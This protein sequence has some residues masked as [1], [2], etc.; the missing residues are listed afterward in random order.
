MRR[1][2]LTLALALTPLF[3]PRPGNAQ[4]APP[5]TA[6][7]TYCIAGMVQAEITG[8]PIPGA[9]VHIL[10][11]KSFKIVQS[12]TADE[13]GHFAF[14]DV[15]AGNFVLQG[16][17]TG[18][19]STDYDNHDGYTTGIVT[20]AG[21]D[22]ESLVLK[23]R[24]QGTLTGTILDESGDPIDH[25]TIHLFRQSHS[26][27]DSRVVTAG[28]NSSNDL[29]HFEFDRLEPGVYLLAVTA[30]PWYA[31]HPMLYQQRMPSYGVADSLDPT[32]D[33]A[34]P[35]TYYPGTTDSS[36][37]TPI[38]VSGSPAD[39]SLRLAPVPALS[40]SFPFSPPQSGQGFVM[41]Q[42]RTSIF[43]Q[44]EFANGQQISQGN[45]QMTLTGLAP[46]DYVLADGRQPINQQTDAATILHL[47]DHNETAEL[48]PAADLAHL[49]ILLKT[50]DGSAVPNGILAGLVPKN[51]TTILDRRNT[52]KGE[53]TFDVTAGDYSLSLCGAQRTTLH[54]DAGST[55]TITTVFEIGEHTIRGFVQRDGKPVAGAFLLL[56]P[57]DEA[58]DLHTYFRNQSD[59]DGSFEM[60]GLAAGTYTLV[61]IDNG[62]DVEWQHPAVLARYLP[63]AVTVKVL[64]SPKGTQTLSE[65]VPLQPR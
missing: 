18:F 45:G 41:P 40:I 58:H 33:V 19:L 20:G 39:I 21:V 27:G 64:D 13:S 6:A 36:E 42:L 57:S 53:I 3:A 38:L 7:A 29:G 8:Q 35:T 23:L 55:E 22:T 5:P 60:S 25:A 46:G 59:L 47:T 51:S 16:E 63:S 4:T 14:T 15:P 32:L 62:W 11:N 56:F 50:T 44:V 30:T 2:L 31:V 10:N 12:V 17:A 48:P 65:P 43:G 1:T 54:L 34:Y 52:A 28:T 9:T 26:F 37:A 49:H 61:S 24:P